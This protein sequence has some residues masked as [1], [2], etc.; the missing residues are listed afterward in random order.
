MPNRTSGD[1]WLDALS[2]PIR[3]AVQR[4]AGVV[5]GADGRVS[6]ALGS[7]RDAALS[8]YEAHGHRIPS[9]AVRAVQLVLPPRMTHRGWA[10]DHDEL[11]VDVLTEPLMGA[12]SQ[13]RDVARDADQRVSGVVTRTRREAVGIC[14]AQ[15]QRIPPPA[16]RVVSLVLPP[17]MTHP[18]WAPGQDELLVDVITEPLMEAVS[19]VRDVARDADSRM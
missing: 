13:V 9:P 11:L 6:G 12:V 18:G 3:G 19:Q 15:A 14:E 5:R 4:V 10:P 16:K 1:P 2:H 7:K 8:L 17:R